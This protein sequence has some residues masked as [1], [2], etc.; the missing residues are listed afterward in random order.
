MREDHGPFLT[1]SI[2]ES[3]KELPES[4]GD[5]ILTEVAGRELTNLAPDAPKEMSGQLKRLAESLGKPNAAFRNLADAHCVSEKQLSCGK[6]GD[7]LLPASPEPAPKTS[8]KPNWSGV[9]V[10]DPDSMSATMETNRAAGYRDEKTYY[11]A[12]AA[13]VKPGDRIGH[14]DALAR[15][16][17]SKPYP[18]NK[19][20]HIA[21]RLKKWEGESRE[22]VG[23]KKTF[24]VCSSN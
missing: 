22:G 23:E 13:R 4:V 17:K 5:K 24:P 10:L 14:L 15:I 21:D 16:A 3:A 11:S 1:D 7:G 18:A 8:K 9:D 6:T 19:A 12:L 20:S 2:C